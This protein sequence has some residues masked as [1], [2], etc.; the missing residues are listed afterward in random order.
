MEKIDP[1]EF[2]RYRQEC[3]RVLRELWL[4]IHPDLLQHHPA[5]EQLTEGQKEQLGKLWHRIMRIRPEELGFDP[6]VIG[7]NNRS[8]EILLDA[9]ASA[10]AILAHSGLDTETS[11]II[12][13]ETLFEQVAWLQR[14]TDRLEHEIE[15]VQ[16]ELK[17]LLEQ[18][19][20]WDKSALLACSPEQQEKARAEMLERAE[21]YRQQ[22]DT[23]EV[24]MST[25]LQKGN[26]P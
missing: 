2:S 11:L 23:L 3:K 21:E 20:I 9:L 8:L 4:L 22:A 17:T 5:Y 15:N 13:G 25:L 24:H 18:D 14:A 1:E 12:E 10:K 7:Y 19:D 16:A 6:G 26:Q